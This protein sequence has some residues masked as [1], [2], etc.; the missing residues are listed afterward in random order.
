MKIGL[1]AT[2]LHQPTGE[3]A[4]TRYL[5]THLTRECPDDEFL[6]LIPTFEDRFAAA[7]VEQ[8]LYPAVDGLF[9]RARYALRV[10]AILRRKGVDVFH[11]LTN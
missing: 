7:N 2:R 8:H 4:Y 1:D 9:D 10:A 6:L 11:N 5:I 3:G